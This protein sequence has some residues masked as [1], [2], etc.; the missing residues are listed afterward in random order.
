MQDV[1]T[2]YEQ[3]ASGASFDLNTMT[4][5]SG[6]SGRRIDID[7]AIPLIDDALRRPTNR[8][9]TL[10]LKAEAPKDRNTATLTDAKDWLYSVKFSPDRKLLAAGTW[11]GQVLLW[12]VADSK[13]LAALFTLKP[14]KQ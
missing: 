2:R 4:F 14:E 10:P 6:N 7:A 9:V 1:A 8:R 3:R 13:P 12:A 11:D 5:G